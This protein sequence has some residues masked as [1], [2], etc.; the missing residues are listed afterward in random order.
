MSSANR[1]AY[2][3]IQFCNTEMACPT[4]ALIET[5]GKTGEKEKKEKLEENKKTRRVR[6]L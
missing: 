2:C 4:K 6:L 3:P 5:S 1:F